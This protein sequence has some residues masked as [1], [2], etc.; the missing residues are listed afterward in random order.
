MSDKLADFK[1]IQQEMQEQVGMSSDSD[2]N[3]DLYNYVEPEVDE[4]VP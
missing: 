1:K 2:D 3:D 4:E